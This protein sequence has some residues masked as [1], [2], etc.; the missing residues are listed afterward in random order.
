MVLF[1]VETTGAISPPAKRYIRELAKRAKA[2][3]SADRT[4]YGSHNNQTKSFQRHHTQRIVR[5]AVAYDAKCARVRVGVQK[6]KA[7]LH[8]GAAAPVG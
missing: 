8:C 4:R 3:G 2:L 1:L 6:R 5:S 7:I